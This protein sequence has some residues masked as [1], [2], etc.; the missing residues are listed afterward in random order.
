MSPITFLTPALTAVLIAAAPTPAAAQSYWA[1]HGRGWF[2][3]EDPPPVPEEPPQEEA[4]KEPPPAAKPPETKQPPAP[5]A[6]PE[7]GTAAWI[8]E[9]LGKYLDR[10]LDAPTAENVRAY[11]VVQRIMMDK[12]S[13][14]TNMQQRIVPG[15][16]YLDE[17]SSRPTATYGANLQ[18]KLAGQNTDVALRRLSESAGIWFFFSS[19]CAYC[20]EQAPVVAAMSRLYGFKIIAVSLDGKPLPSGLFPDWRPDQGQA[21]RLGVERTP[22]TVLVRPPDGF[23]VLGRGM[24]SIQDLKTRALIQALNAGWIS[25]EEYDDTSPVVRPKPLPIASSTSTGEPAGFLDFI[26]QG[27]KQ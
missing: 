26:R 25:Q 22:T 24:L 2:W 10:A 8:R 15:D 23:Q 12:A 21:S 9:N 13:T 19:T 1:D 27:T 17:I 11:Y 5:P 3:Y 18:N 14:F 6:P 16:P 7:F 20:V 4:T